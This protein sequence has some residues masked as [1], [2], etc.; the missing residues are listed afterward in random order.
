MQRIFYD[1]KFKKAQKSD[2]KKMR[3]GGGGKRQT[4]RQTQTQRDT[5][6]DRQRQTDRDGQ[7]DSEL[8]FGIR[9]V[10]QAGAVKG[11]KPTQ[12]P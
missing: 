6:T 8:S 7:R 1:V 11:L 12:R 4:D 5:K 9:I 2:R 10:V 3:E